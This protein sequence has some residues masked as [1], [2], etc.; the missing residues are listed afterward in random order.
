MTTTS[1]PNLVYTLIDHAPIT[2]GNHAFTLLDCFES[3]IIYNDPFVGFDRI[4]DVGNPFGLTLFDKF[5][6]PELTSVP[7]TTFEQATDITAM[8][9]AKLIENSDLPIAVHWSGGIDSTVILS[10]MIK[11]FNPALQDRVVVVMNNASYFE[12]P[13]FFEKCI[14]NYIP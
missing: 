9:L 4:N 5:R 8:R 2:N 14:K 13:Y 1:Y 10:A 12:N 3:R 7:S 6:A 11:N